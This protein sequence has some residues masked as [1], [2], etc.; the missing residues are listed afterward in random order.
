M[1]TITV[2]RARAGK[3]P[4]QHEAPPPSADGVFI[5]ETFQESLAKKRSQ[6]EL[7]HARAET[8]WWRL[9]TLL[10]GGVAII[11]GIGWNKA[12]TRYANSVRVAWVKVQ[13][14]G[15]SQVEYFDDGQSPARF[16]QAQINAAFMNYLEHRYRVQPESIVADY[17]YVLDFYGDAMRSQFLDKKGFNAAKV[18]AEIEAN[19]ST[20][21]TDVTVRALDHDTLNTPDKANKY[22]GTY[23]TTAYLTLRTRSGNADPV[24]AQKIV[25]ITWSLHRIED[26]PK[27][28]SILKVNS[29]GL[30]ILSEKVIDDLSGP[31]K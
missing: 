9:A 26:L 3:K 10:M 4:A 11:M 31:A 15:A 27:D 1:D 7:A 14:N 18:A 17:G 5:P 2:E 19:P 30:Q 21:R 24:P 22:T 6:I 12:D 28:L 25:K 29:P 8:N 13:P 20:P 23:E 16:F